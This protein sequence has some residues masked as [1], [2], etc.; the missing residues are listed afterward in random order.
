MNVL[1]VASEVFPLVKT[2]GLADVAAQLPRAL[3][4]LGVDVKVLLP[5]Y[6]GVLERC[7]DARRLGALTALDY[8]AVLW[9]WR[10]T[11]GVEHLLLDCPPLYDRPGGPYQNE[12]GEDWPDNALRFGLLCAAAARLCGPESPLA[13]RPRLLHAHDWQAGL[14]PLWAKAAGG[15]P[16]VFTVHNLAYQ[17]VFDRS[18]FDRLGLPDPLWRPEGL[19]FYG[20]WSFMKAAL[21]YADRLTTVSPRYAEEIQTPEFG[22][23]LDGVLR[24]RRDVLRGI[25]NG[26]DTTLWDP[27]RD[28]YL[29]AHYDREDLSGK[30]AAKAELQHAL[31]LPKA[32]E[33]FLLGMVSRLTTQK[34]VD[35][36]LDASGALG[37]RPLQ[38]AVLGSGERRLET[39][40]RDAAA[41]RP[42]RFAVR[43]GYDEALAHRLIAGADGFL[44]PSRFEP[45]GLTQL[46]SLRYGTIPLVHPV[47]GLA[48]TV[49]D[50]DRHPEGNGFH[51]QP[52][53]AA[54]LVETVD[55][56][57]AHYGDGAAWRR[58]QRHAMAADHSWD[59]SA[60]A[61]LALYEELA[62]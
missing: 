60:R 22:C 24:A 1:F 30:R 61:Y 14:A 27:A 48:D 29:T 8:E 5:A 3:A 36:L 34:G 17:G 9:G 23:G 45:C 21:V 42:H 59:R 19:E 37:D 26:I 16:S 62:A 33:A 44:M 40:L 13:W 55:R 43:I 53:N 51:I 47:G 56:A 6:R 28:P 41:T 57:M 35:V 58:L 10:A 4:A 39:A 18:D 54:A 46:Y 20:R 32:P 31:G 2:G 52:L 7:P 49:F 12:A 38:L 50:A 15:V 25:L 11:D